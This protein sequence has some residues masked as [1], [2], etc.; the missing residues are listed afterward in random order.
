MLVTVNVAQDKSSYRV[1]GQAQH[2]FILNENVQLSR[3]LLKWIQLRLSFG[4]LLET[5]ERP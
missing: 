5:A 2:S 4:K 1:L 3:G